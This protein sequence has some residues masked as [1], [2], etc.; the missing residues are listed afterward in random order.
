[1]SETKNLFIP[2]YYVESHKNVKIKLIESFNY[3]CSLIDEIIDK[4]TLDSCKNKLYTINVAQESISGY[5]HALHTYLIDYI[6]NKSLDKITTLIQEL[7]KSELL[8][9]DLKIYGF[10][11][12]SLGSHKFE[13]YKDI[14]LQDD[15]YK[16]SFNNP[17][18][19]NERQAKEKISTA[20]LLIKQADKNL[21]NEIIKLVTEIILFENNTTNVASSGTSF[22]CY[23]TI[24]IACNIIDSIPFYI[25]AIVHEAA[26]LYLFLIVLE[27]S[28]VLNPESER[29]P[30]PLRKDMRPMMGIYHATF[31]IARILY[32][33]NSLLKTLPLSHEIYEELKQR[34][35]GHT[36]NFQRGINVISQYGRLTNQGK[37]ILFDAANTLN[38][39][40]NL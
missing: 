25:E 16:M 17:S 21:Y 15:K 33:F 39:K 7:E 2:G 1:M 3:L 19:K 31:V 4:D 8:I 29:Y 12:N 5:A 11:P 23:G 22:N 27:D 32:A 38:I 9:Y 20:L 10:D 18:K 28:I 14:F 34:R 36:I 30:A 13:L 24:F 40:I 37:G 35:D 6:E 26:H